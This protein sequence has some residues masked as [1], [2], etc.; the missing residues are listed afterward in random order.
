M[1]LIAESGSSKTDWLLVSNESETK[2]SSKGYN[3]QIASSS[4]IL[5]DLNDCF[6]KIDVSTI[7]DIFFY[8]AGC[9]AESSKNKLQ[10]ILCIF[11]TNSRITIESDLLAACRA[12]LG[13]KEGI[14]G[15][16]GTGS[17]CCYY[18]GKKIHQKT[19]S[20]GYI[21]GDE[22]SGNDI[23]KRVIKLALY[24]EIDSNTIDS[25]FGVNFN[26]NELISSI[27]GADR[28][29]TYLASFMKKIYPLRNEE[30]IKSQIIDSFNSYFVNHISKYS[31]SSKVYLA[32][33]ISVLFRSEL[34]D[35]ALLHGKTLE[36][37]DSNPIEGLKKYHLNS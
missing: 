24:N 28:I 29:N 7:E 27:Y 23:A 36:K 35:I 26:P 19:T 6:K 10:K 9:A 11:F 33:S 5:E 25:I 20:L 14:I 31:E 22:G 37:C 15:I 32:G 3:P 2:L 16:L 17:N 12:L 13:N 21:L 30:S 8:G 34:E 4:F 1:I 18:D